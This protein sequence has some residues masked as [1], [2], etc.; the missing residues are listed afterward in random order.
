MLDSL[1]D[2]LIRLVIL[3]SMHMLTRRAH[4]DHPEKIDVRCFF[5]SYDK[6]VSLQYVIY[7]LQL[8]SILIMMAKKVI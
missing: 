5:G 4:L 3:G 1:V 2:A 7:V 6:I 8:R